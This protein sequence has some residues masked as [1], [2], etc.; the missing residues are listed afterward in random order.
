MDGA[1][2]PEGGLE[3]GAAA[4]AAGAQG[5]P[6]R[7]LAAELLE[8]ATTAEEAD[9]DDAG[10]SST[11]PRAIAGLPDSLDLLLCMGASPGAPTRPE[12]LFASL[13][14]G[15]GDQGRCGRL[16]QSNEIVYRCQTCGVDP[17]CVMCSRCFDAS[18]HEGHD[19]M[20]Y[21]SGGRG[22]CCDG[23]DPEAWLPSAPQILRGVKRQT[24]D[25]S[26]NKQMHFCRLLSRCLF[27][28]PQ[29]HLS[30]PQPAPLTDRHHLRTEAEKSWT[31]AEENKHAPP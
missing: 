21:R 4:A 9:D 28:Q 25:E 18:A 19:V 8:R 31:A 23:G 5:R 17:T 14:A 1:G 3:G 22:G 16:F 15:G 6:L 30:S 29:Q 11:E 26:D 13:A 27:G 2:G 10:A 7:A 24:T 12:E 20:F